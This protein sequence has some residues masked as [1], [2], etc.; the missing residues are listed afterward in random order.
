MFIQRL[1]AAPFKPFSSLTVTIE[2]VPRLIMACGINGSGKSSFIDAI[3][4]W[5]QQQHWGI[6]DPTYYSRG[7]T[8]S[9]PQGGQVML[10]FHGEPPADR[11]MAVNVRTAQRVT[12]DFN[13]GSIGQ[14]EDLLSDPGP[15]RTIDLD[16]RV[17]QNYRRLMAESVRRLWDRNHPQMSDD[18]I[19][20]LV[21]SIAEPLGRLLPGFCSRAQASILSRT[22]LSSS[23]RARSSATRTSC[24][25]VG[26]RPC[27]TC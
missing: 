5:R 25:P 6:Q 14:P 3:S 8:P 7:G 1:H 13:I 21:G 15:R 16:T 2:E 10:E 19:G 26:R 24:S 12:V 9:S 22:G 20:T 18:I 4:L 27:S 11:R 23:R 17:E